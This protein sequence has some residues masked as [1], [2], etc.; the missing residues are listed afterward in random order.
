MKKKPA[1]KNT[2][3]GI[4]RDPLLDKTL[5]LIENEGVTKAY[6][7]QKSGLAVTTLSNWMKG[8]TRRPQS[9][10][11]Q[12]ALSSIGYELTVRRKK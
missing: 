12:F 3:R 9:V 4:T 6:I 2:V 1:K 5:D 10:S 11:L 8:K 7:S